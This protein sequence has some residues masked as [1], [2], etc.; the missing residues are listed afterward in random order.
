MI[1]RKHANHSIRID[2]LQNECRC[3][4]GRC[5][6]AAGRL[7]E[8]L[9]RNQVWE[10]LENWRAKVLVSDDPEAVAGGKR[11]K[12][13]DGFLNHGFRAIEGKQL[14]RAMFAAQWPEAG[15]AAA[16]EDY[17]IEIRYE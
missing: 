6:V 12:A 5:G 2:A 7:G 14:L 9:I 17:R 15:A 11:C 16:G 10:L 8:N 13:F 1:G 4:D 3:S